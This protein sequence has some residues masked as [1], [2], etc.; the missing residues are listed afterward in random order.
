M[1]EQAGHPID[2]ATPTP[3]AWRRFVRERTGETPPLTMTDGR[4]PEFRHLSGGYDPADPIDRAV[5]A[6]RQAVF[7]LHGLDPMP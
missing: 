3:E 2:P 7:P 5:M 4:N 6:T 1:A